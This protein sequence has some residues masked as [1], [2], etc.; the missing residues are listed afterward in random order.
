MCHAWLQSYT[1]FY[2]IFSKSTVVYW[3]E[4]EEERSDTKKWKLDSW[5]YVKEKD[6]VYNKLWVS[7]KNQ[8]SRNKELLKKEMK[9]ET[10]FI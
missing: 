3:G 6:M 8:I 9:I 2:H 1:I 5:I 7:K 10:Q 4:K